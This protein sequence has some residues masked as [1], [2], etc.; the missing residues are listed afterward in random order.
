[1]DYFN[2]AKNG[3]KRQ[4]DRD[5]HSRSILEKYNT[6]PQQEDQEMGDD[7]DQAKASAYGSTEKKLSQEE[8]KEGGFV[9]ANAMKF[10]N[11]MKEQAMMDN[12]MGGVEGFKMVGNNKKLEI[13]NTH[14]TQDLF[15]A[16]DMPEDDAVEFRKKVNKVKKM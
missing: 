12:M 15:N 9:K 6:K 2:V 10:R 7:E 1:M 8:G 14:R 11:K 3:A 5:S 13:K 16:L 4:R